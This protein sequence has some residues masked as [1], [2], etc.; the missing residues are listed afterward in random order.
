M[1]IIEGFPEARLRRPDWAWVLLGSALLGRVAWAVL[2]PCVDYWSFKDK[3]AEIAGAP[4][5]GNDE[6]LE[7]VMLAAAERGLEAQVK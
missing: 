5:R 6:V 7:L 3:V 4:V 1:H 2:L